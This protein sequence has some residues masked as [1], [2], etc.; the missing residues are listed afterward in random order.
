MNT[1]NESI[2]DNSVDSSNKPLDFSGIFKADYNDNNHA[3]EKEYKSQIGSTNALA[4]ILKTNIEKG[5]DTSDKESMINRVKM[6]GTNESL[7]EEPLRIF[8]IIVDCFEDQTLRV[9]LISAIISLVIGLFKDGIKTGWIEGSAIFSAVFIV[10]GISSYLNYNEKMQFRML[11]LENKSKSVLVIRDGL[12]REI[13]SENLLVGD[14]LLLKI[15]DIVEVDGLLVGTDEVKVDESAVN[16]ESVLVKKTEEFI[17]EDNKYSTPIIIS[18]SKIEEGK[19]KIIVCAVGEKSFSGRNKRLIKSTENKSEDDVTPLKK[20]LNDLADKIGTF[21]FV[22]G[23]LIGS[24][25]VIKEIILRLRHGNSIFNTEMLDV[26]VNAF[27]LGVTVIV[28]AIPEGLPMAVAI[29]LA[30]SL[31]KMK[32][33]HNLVKN[34][35]S[36][37][38][39]GNV[40][41]V[42]TDK[43]GTL[44]MGEMKVN[45]I[46]LHGK[47]VTIA[48]TKIED[49]FNRPSIENVYDCIRKNISVVESEDINGKKV[50][51][52]DMTEKALYDFANPSHFEKKKEKK[53]KYE[54]PFKSDYKF[55]MTIYKNEKDKN[56]KLYAKGAF[57]HL[58]SFIT[59]MKVDN[60]KSID[61]NSEQITKQLS[62]YAEES[63]RTLIFATKIVSAEEMKKSE[64]KF[65]EKNVEF[66]SSLA[67]GMT[68]EFIIGITDPLRPDVPNAISLCKH[69]SITVRMITGDN[70]LTALA[71]SKSAGILTEEEIKE[72]K[73][74]NSKI[75][76]LLKSKKHFSHLDFESPIALTGEDFRSLSGN[77]CK[78][79]DKETGKIVLSLN[80]VQKF[81]KATAKLKVIARASPEDKFL[82]V[83][84]LKS[85]NNIVAVTGDGTNDAPALKTAHVG[86]AMGKRGTDIAKEAADIILLD[87]SFS[88][89]ITACKFGRNVYDCIRKFIQFQLTTNIVAVF[90]SLLGGVVLK[91]SP[92]NCIEMLWVN[93]IMDSFAS[94][95][96]A[97]ESPTEELLERKPY[98]REDNLLTPMMIINVIT[99]GIFQII[100]LS[101]VLFYGDVIFGVASDRDLEHFVWN[102]V[103]GYHFTLFFDVFVFLQ[104]FNSVNARK[105]RKKEINIFKGILGNWYYLL[106]QMF[107]IV[108]QII[109]VTFGG[110]AVRV[111]RL[112]IIQHM[113]CA[114]LASLSI[115]VGFVIKVAL[116]C[117]S[118]KK[119]VKVNNRNKVESRELLM[120]PKSPKNESENRKLK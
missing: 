59:K 114:A 49:A 110:R 96:L 27:I 71:I 81:N 6:F 62:V 77:L 69:A 51:T 46:F 56:F 35:D 112:S 33:E 26:L 29:A 99:Q 15:G 68:F 75:S 89:I 113:Q 104:V 70:L 5:I 20:H 22:S 93:L 83:F 118:C 31:Q 54:L 3:S 117:I 10:V 107:I 80:D 84:G 91:D 111:K 24:I 100:V 76:S 9:L 97:T 30:Y 1:T 18:G 48:N 87:D 95:A 7:P 103:N 4:K 73:N 94:L 37:E 45:S 64:E 23:I 41:N 55:M 60:D 82:L 8:D 36:S 85:T 74:I 14:L 102:D 28:V 17:N 12:E 43:T 63:M 25:M 38:T 109:I 16:G 40:N 92:L 44:T 108:G 88:S 78:K 98:K 61:I 52:G 2:L 67:N 53:P 47:N 13:K 86:F 120:S 115:L 90:M 34:L 119:T 105:L 72:S 106:V 101:I 11:S 42:C 66:F 116:C 79:T 32:N 50:L 21:G 57:E 65:K 58:S 19:G 39:M